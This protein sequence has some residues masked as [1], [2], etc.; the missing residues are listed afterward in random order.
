MHA[1]CVAKE[2]PAIVMEYAEMGTL[3]QVLTTGPPLDLNAEFNM[4]IGVARGICALRR[5]LRF[6][7]VAGLSFLHKKDVIHR[8]IAA[9]NILVYFFFFADCVSLNSQL[10]D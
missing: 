1:V 4:I 8:D 6:A 3:V 10:L 5:L 2:S 9:R 7:H